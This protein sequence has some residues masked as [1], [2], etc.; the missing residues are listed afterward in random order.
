[1]PSL[2]PDNNAEV[3]SYINSVMDLFNAAGNDRKLEIIMTQKWLSSVGSP[4][5]QYTDYRRT[6]FRSCTIPTTMEILIHRASGIMHIHSHGQ[7]RSLHSIQMPL[8]KRIL[9]PSGYSG[10]ISL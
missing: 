1:V 10:I 6:G 4:V 7:M 5:D 9:Q 2:D 3:A 8:N